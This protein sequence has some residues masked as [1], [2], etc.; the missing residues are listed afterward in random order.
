LIAID[1]LSPS[2]PQVRFKEDFVDYH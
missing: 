2:L 1:C